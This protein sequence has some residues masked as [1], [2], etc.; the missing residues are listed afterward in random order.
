MAPL[1]NSA[2]PL[3]ALGSKAF[4]PPAPPWILAVSYLS[5]V[6]KMRDPLLHFLPLLPSRVDGSGEV[7]QPC[8]CGRRLKKSPPD[9][10]VFL[11]SFFFFLLSPCL[12]SRMEPMQDSLSLF[13]FSLLCTRYD[14]AAILLIYFAESQLTFLFFTGDSLPVKRFPPLPDAMT[15]VALPMP[16]SSGI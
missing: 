8:R 2:N 13:F 11:S 1:T 15:S 14:F 12:S 4:F 3:M 5:P 9:F 16:A 7:G 10:W 6:P